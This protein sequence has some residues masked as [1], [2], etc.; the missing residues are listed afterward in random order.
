MK[1]VRFFIKFAF[2]T[3]L[4]LSLLIFSAIF[5]LKNNISD[6]YKIKKGEGLS[7]NTLLPIRAEFGGVE[8]SRATDSSKIG[9][10][11]NVDLNVFGVIPFT[12]VNVQVVD[13]MYVSVLGNPF[14][15]KLY[16]EGVLIIELTD[17]ETNEGI[18]TPAK[19]CGLKVG[20][21][22]LSANGEKVSTNEDLSRIVEES[23]G[24][25]IKLVV[26]RNNKK[27]HINIMAQIS[28]ETGNY[29]IG[30][31]VRD[32]SAGIGTL[33][34]YSPTSGVICGLGHGICD[35]DTGEI[36]NIEKGEIVNAD[37]LS[38]EKGAVG[39]PGQLNGKFGNKS[40][41]VIKLNCSQGVYSILNGSMDFSQMTE[42]SLKNEVKDGSA[43]I[44]CTVEGSAPKLY[45]CKI[46]VRHS[47]FHSKTQNLLITVTDEELLNIT[48]G[49]VQGMSG[50]PILQ[51][52][53]LVGAVTHVLIDDPTKGYGIFAENILETA[54]SVNENN[55]L[56]ET[57]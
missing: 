32:S 22:I 26:I 56:K 9:E 42:V 34:F 17:V 55:K 1:V 44:L 18:K 23:D 45:S 57:G 10:S 20:D 21:Y 43:Q 37:I 31:W 16:T 8:L 48:G 4:I 5:Y 13:E 11:Y 51:N 53:K 30:V 7:F 39:S 47:S 24:E 49:I 6:D 38:V 12:T 27:I 15:M 25:K 35:D 36:L 52:G 3:G 50:S 19:D 33:T 41:G 46:K 29:K 14:G 2:F 54:Q 28:K 40:L